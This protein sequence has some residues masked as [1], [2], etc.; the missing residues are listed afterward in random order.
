MYILS[1]YEAPRIFVALFWP[2]TLELSQRTTFCQ[3]LCFL[4]FSKRRDFDSCL[5]KPPA[6]RSGQIWSSF[7]ES[8]KDSVALAL[9]SDG[10]VEVKCEP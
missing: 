9:E 10:R 4:A 7:E 1:T 3:H 2:S 5:S 6:S 8:C